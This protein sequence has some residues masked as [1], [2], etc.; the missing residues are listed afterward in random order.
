MAQIR[1]EF[2]LFR[3]LNATKDHKSAEEAVSRE[4]GNALF[5]NLTCLGMITNGFVGWELGSSSYRKRLRLSSIVVERRT[6]AKRCRIYKRS[7][8]LNTKRR[9]IR[10]PEDKRSEAGNE[11]RQ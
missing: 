5:K 3:A 11:G 2:N 6:E 1:H 8:D 10:L 4:S 9:K 7:S